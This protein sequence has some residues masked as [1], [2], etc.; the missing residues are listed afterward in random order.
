MTL[1]H[2]PPTAPRETDTLQF[3][4]ENRP[5][6]LRDRLRAD[7]STLHRQL[8]DRLATLDLTQ[9]Q[10]RRAFCLIQ[11][12]G[13]A[14][15]GTACDW[16]A[17]EATEVLKRQMEALRA[18]TG[19]TPIEMVIP[20][21]HADAVAYV[22]LGSQLGTEMMRRGLDEAQQTGYF[23]QTPDMTA[24]RNFCD[25]MRDTDPTS[26]EGLTIRGNACTAFAVFLAAADRV[27]GPLPETV[28]AEELAA[29][30]AAQ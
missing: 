20:R 6:T 28:S 13:F 29:Q 8:D 11:L 21:L 3:R 23:G 15:L 16:Q 7:T 14:A 26:A 12:H 17:A 18:E 5:E 25:R 30:I 4:N 10:R 27:L 22:A 2:T 24:W 9:P 19:E 1:T